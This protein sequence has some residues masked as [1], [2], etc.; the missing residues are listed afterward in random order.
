[1]TEVAVRLRPQL[2]DRAGDLADDTERLLQHG[3]HFFDPPLASYKLFLLRLL[4]LDPLQ[5]FFSPLQLNDKLLLL[6]YHFVIVS[7]QQ[8]QLLLVVLFK[9]ELLS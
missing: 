1:V 9:R 4:P 6:R 3:L 8:A 5:L 7:L 2:L